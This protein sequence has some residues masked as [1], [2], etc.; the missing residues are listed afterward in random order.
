VLILI[1]RR[2]PI[3]AA[4]PT[5][6][7][8]VVR[9]QRGAAYRVCVA[10]SMSVIAMNPS[11]RRIPR[12][13]VLECCA[14]GVKVVCC[15]GE[16]QSGQP[17]VYAIADA[18]FVSRPLSSNCLSGYSCCACGEYLQ[19]RIVKWDVLIERIYPQRLA[20]SMYIHIQPKGICSAGIEAGHL[21]V[22]PGS[23][24]RNSYGS[25]ATHGSSTNLR[26]GLSSLALEVPSV[27]ELIGKELLE[28]RYA[29]VHHC[30]GG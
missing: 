23:Q 25:C 8:Q 20:C 18:G 2:P 7:E 9:V 28:L 15:R 24:D 12:E 5:T 4:V 10:V 30:Q 27:G 16:W 19:K 1:L 11:R 22:G 13:G 17:T 6:V 21:I 3:V 29:K 26:F 14:E